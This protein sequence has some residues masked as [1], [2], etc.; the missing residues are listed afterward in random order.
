MPKGNQNPYIEEDNTMARRK[1]SKG[2]TAIYKHKYKTKDRVIR[3]P[4]KT[5][6]NSTV[7]FVRANIL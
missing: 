2:Q 6:V 4:L 3:T 7:L 5:M 1:S